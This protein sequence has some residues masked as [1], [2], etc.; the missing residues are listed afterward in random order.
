MASKKQSFLEKELADCSDLMT[1]MSTDNTSKVFNKNDVIDY[2]YPTGIVLVDHYLGYEINIRD[3]IDGPIIG[4]RKC[5]GLQAGT[6]NAIT[7]S[8]QS[9]KTTIGVGI[10]KYIADQN[11]GNIIHYDV[12]QRLVLQR[13]KNLTGLPDSWFTGDHP[14]YAIKCGAIGYDTLQEDIT[15]IWKAKMM[16]KSLLLRDTGVVD[17]HNQPIKLMPPTIV[18]L[19][20][21][22]DVISKEYDINNS[23]SIEDLGE[24]RTD[25]YGMRSAKTLRGVLTD[26]LP[27][28]KEANILFICIA[29]KGANVAMNAFAGP[30]KQFQ[31][32][33]HDEKMSGGKVVE[34]SAS[35]VW[36]LTSEIREDSRYHLSSDGFEGNTV[37]FEPIKVST[38]ESGN[39]KTGR[40]CRLVIDKRINGVDNIRSLILFLNQ[41]GHLKGNKAG[42]RVINKQGEPISEKFTWKTVYDDFKKNPEI[43]KVFMT[44][45]KEELDALVAKAPDETERKNDIF[46]IDAALNSLN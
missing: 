8:T 30:K 28:L 46:D 12:E 32:G 40:G 21:L 15:E 7:G 9:Y 5:L 38:N 37:L 26:I 31:Y 27:M 25:T 44:T 11:D 1:I 4:K 23:K 17:D 2:S 14:R 6:F 22:S 43:F 20:S 36:N 24:L 35:S 45:A 3:G 19:D 10:C 33:A 18:F 13:V 16:K 34:Y 39:E 42:F 29:H 41:K